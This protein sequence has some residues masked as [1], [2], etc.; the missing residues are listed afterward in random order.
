MKLGTLNFEPVESHTELVSEAARSG[1]AKHGLKDILVA[2]IDPEL[3]DTAAFCEQYKIGLDISVNCVIVEAKR[4]DRVW[5]AACLI[6]ATHRID[7][8]GVVRRAL[9]A[10]KASFAS[11]DKATSLSAMAYGAISPIGLPDDWPILV[12]QDIASLERVIIG[13][14]VRKSKLL[15]SGGIFSSLPNAQITDIKKA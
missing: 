5:Y 13:S 1:I 6:R 12:D 10:K 11:M 9:D 15:V 4:A 2:E 7:I 3:S 14:G 8:N